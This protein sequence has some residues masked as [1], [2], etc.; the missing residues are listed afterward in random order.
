MPQARGEVPAS[1]AQRIVEAVV[2][3]REAEVERDLA[4]TA[5]LKAGGSVREVA[6]IAG[7]SPSRIAQ[8]GHAN[9]WPSEAQ[10]DARDRLRQQNLEWRRWIEDGI[11]RVLA[12]QEAEWQDNGE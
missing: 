11:A 8:I 12:K 7:L 9:G 5:A 4:I 2:A 1:K 6:A 10:K 3:L